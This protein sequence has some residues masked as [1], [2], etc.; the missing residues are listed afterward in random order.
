[1][2]DLL[3]RFAQIIKNDSTNF[4]NSE[5]GNFPSYY[6]DK[7]KA[8][9]ELIRIHA[10]YHD[11]NSNE[12]YYDSNQDAVIQETL[13]SIQELIELEEYVVAQYYIVS[14]ELLMGIEIKL[15]RIIVNMIINN[16][17]I[18]EF[19]DKEK[20]LGKSNPNTNYN[21]RRR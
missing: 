16:N 2:D 9:S 20:Y 3:I 10:Y 1:M 21:D 13:D 18:S 19:V 14:L 17:Q 7:E 15:N 5:I 4:L 12:S 8:E 11:K 6:G